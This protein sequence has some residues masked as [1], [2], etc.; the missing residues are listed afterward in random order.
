M[1]AW[2]CYIPDFYWIEIYRI[3]TE[4]NGFDI[5]GPGFYDLLVLDK[6]ALQ[7]KIKKL[8]NITSVA[9]HRFLLHGSRA[10]NTH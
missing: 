1:G 5:R 7:P 10:K 9:L 3:A 6:R 2:R 8:A 4:T